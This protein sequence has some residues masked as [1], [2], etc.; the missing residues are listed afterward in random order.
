ME[1]TQAINELVE[2]LK[3]DKSMRTLEY[4]PNSDN[5]HIKHVEALDKLL[6]SYSRTKELLKEQTEINRKLTTVLLH[7]NV[8]KDMIKRR[9][10][11]LKTSD[12]A[13][14]KIKI[15]ALEGIL[16]HC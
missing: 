15:D 1:L 4:D 14:A 16:E 13:D 7:D 6:E 11:H 3:Y 12:D 5:P 10:R 8:P 2:Y 9:I